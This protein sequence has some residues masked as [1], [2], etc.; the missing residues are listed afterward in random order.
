MMLEVMGQELDKGEKKT[1][2]QTFNE[3]IVE[4]PAGAKKPTK[5]KRSYEVA[6]YEK[7]GEKTTHA[8]QGKTVVIAKKGDKYEFTVDGSSLEPENSATPRLGRTYDMTEFYGPTAAG[9]LYVGGPHRF[10]VG[11]TAVIKIGT[12]P[13]GDPIPVV[14]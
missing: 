13:V 5:L 3:E 1:V 4:K 2:R 10:A 11:D 8:Y 9:A 14:C 7:D 6:E 12:A